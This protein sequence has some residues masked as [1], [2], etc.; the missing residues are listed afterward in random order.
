M[1][2]VFVLGENERVEDV[3]APPSNLEVM[4]EVIKTLV[5]II[6]HPTGCSETHNANQIAAAH[7]L[8]G[9]LEMRRHAK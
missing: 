7:E 1:D 4:N 8:L 2:N 3:Y 9:Y 6:K 5:L